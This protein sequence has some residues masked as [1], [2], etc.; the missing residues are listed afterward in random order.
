MQLTRPATCITD[1]DTGD[2]VAVN[3]E[4]DAT[5]NGSEAETDAPSTEPVAEE[6]DA[7]EPVAGEASHEDVNSLVFDEADDENGKV[8][9]NDSLTISDSK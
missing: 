7:E 9:I 4:Q 2:D 1:I 5:S 6:P 8:F 3:A